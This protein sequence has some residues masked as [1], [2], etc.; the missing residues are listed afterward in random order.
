MPAALSLFG[1]CLTYWERALCAPGLSPA[2]TRT[3]THG[4][5]VSLGALGETLLKL[6]DIH[7]A[8]ACFEHNRALMAEIAGDIARADVRLADCA[9]ALARQG[10]E[11][12]QAQYLRHAEDYLQQAESGYRERPHVWGFWLKAQL[13]LRLM[14]RQWTDVVTVTERCLPEVSVAFV[15]GYLLLY[16]GQAWLALENPD[17]AVAA[18]AASATAFLHEHYI[19]EAAGAYLE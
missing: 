9:M 18:C 13:K 7:G 15:K 3:L 6:H 5:A 19:L 12:L 10:P 17:T 2:Y 1:H 14:Q 8:I 11:A 16:Q 4:L